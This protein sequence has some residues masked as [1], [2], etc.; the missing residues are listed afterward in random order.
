MLSMNFQRCGVK[1]NIK[2][3]VFIAVDE[4]AV[5]PLKFPKP[6]AIVSKAPPNKHFMQLIYNF[7]FMMPELFMGNDFVKLLSVGCVTTFN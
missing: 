5:C 1:T 3:K 6:Q 4:P 2:L 7:M